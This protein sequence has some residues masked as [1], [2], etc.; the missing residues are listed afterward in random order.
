VGGGS[1]EG[2]IDGSIG[3]W[4]D[5]LASGGPAPGGGAVGAMSTAMAAGLVSMVCNLTVGRTDGD[6][7]REAAMVEARAR[8]DALRGRALELSA[9]DGAAFA[10]VSRAYRMPEDTEDERAARSAAIQEGLVG[11]AE[12][13]LRSAE[14]AGEVVAL[15]RRVLDGANPRVLSDL[16]VAVA[17]ARASL[18]AAVLNVEVNLA[19]MT[20]ADTATALRARLQPHLGAL[21]TATEV[22][23]SVRRRIVLPG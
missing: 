5:G 23:D 21:V 2:T 20:D 16:G 15:A 14:V 6:A 4:L 17:A 3:G 11:A 19:S 8:A 18:E 22:L 13:P 12:V 1:A 7:D 10:E 9:A